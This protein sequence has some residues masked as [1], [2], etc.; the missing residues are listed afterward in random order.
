ML[1]RR[2]WRH[3]RMNKNRKVDMEILSVAIKPVVASMIAFVRP[4]RTKADHPVVVAVI[5]AIATV[6]AA[7]IAAAA[8]VAVAVIAGGTAV[9]V[10]V[11]GNGDDEEEGEGDRIEIA[12]GPGG[13]RQTRTVSESDLPSFVRGYIDRDID[14]S[15][16]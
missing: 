11:L 15:T 6:E 8:S 12:P 3:F 10:T 16:S 2:F 1:S 13:R 9:A 7:A 14:T 4:R 5:G